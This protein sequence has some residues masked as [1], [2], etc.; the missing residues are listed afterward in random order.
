[1]QHTAS[2]TAASTRKLQKDAKVPAPS[3]KKKKEKS[4]NERYVDFVDF[5]VPD[6]GSGAA[7]NAASASGAGGAGALS[8]DEKVDPCCC[9][10][11]PWFK[12]LRMLIVV[13]YRR[14]RTVIWRL[15]MVATVESA[16]AA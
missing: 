2:L 15:A 6:M 7:A 9:C 10:C 1:M 16:G 14:I 4:K 5:N 8:A 12:C 3:F 13:L 11:K